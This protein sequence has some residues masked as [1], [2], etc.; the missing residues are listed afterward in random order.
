MKDIGLFSSLGEAWTAVLRTIFQQGS[1]TSYTDNAGERADAKEIFGLT[2]SVVNAHLPD[3]VIERHKVPA[4][5][6]W[7][8]RNFTV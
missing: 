3:A 4:E 7:M 6:D 8:A 2:F 5:Y 1:A